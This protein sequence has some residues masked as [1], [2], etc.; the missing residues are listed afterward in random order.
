MAKTPME[1]SKLKLI[2][3]NLELLIESLKIEV[4][5]DA[6]SYLHEDVEG[7]YKYGEQYDDDGDPD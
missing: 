5:S 3:H 4:Y 1:K 7:R 2:V 6:S